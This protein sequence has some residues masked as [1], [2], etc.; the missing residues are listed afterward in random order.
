[1][2]TDKVNNVNHWKLSDKIGDPEIK[3]GWKPQL[4]WSDKEAQYQCTGKDRSFRTFDKIINTG[5]VK[6][7]ED[8]IREKQV[9]ELLVRQAPRS[10]Q[11]ELAKR[12]Q[13][14]KIKE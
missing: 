13:E 7:A 3:S 8:T 4:K 10:L 1:M 6:N 9:E 12:I 2:V 11:G 5:Q 14:E